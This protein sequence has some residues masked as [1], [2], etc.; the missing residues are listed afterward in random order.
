M[1]IF[2]NP[3]WIAIMLLVFL[4]GCSQSGSSVPF[5][6]QYVRTNGYH[7]GKEYPITS[8]VTSTGE[9]TAYYDKYKNEYDFERRQQIASDSTTGFLDAVDKYTETYFQDKVLLIILV[10]EGSGSNRHKITGI[11]KE[12][13]LMTV[14]VERQI[15]QVGTADMAQW[16]IL[17]EIDRDDWKDQEIRVSFTEKKA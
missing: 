5:S 15:P 4:A 1:K 9:L 8:V 3:L 17:V 14:H 7:E 6:V 16:H 13:G 2:K 10:Q 11:T 12:D